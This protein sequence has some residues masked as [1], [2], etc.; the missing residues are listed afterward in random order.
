M[1]NLSKFI[2]FFTIAALSISYKGY[3]L[4]VLWDWFLVKTFEFQSISIPTAIG[5]TLIVNFI[6]SQPKVNKES[7]DL[8][9]EAFFKM[10][11]IGTVIPTLTL[12]MGWITTL[13]M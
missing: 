6:I 13:F 1:S 2:F 10:A 3:A 7:E 11:L 9:A 12:L 5:I 4:S 8:D